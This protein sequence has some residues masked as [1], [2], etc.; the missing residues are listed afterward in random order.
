V[1][2]EG[3]DGNDMMVAGKTAVTSSSLLPEKIYDGGW[4]SDGYVGGSDEDM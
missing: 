3:Y 2:S 1:V 4:P